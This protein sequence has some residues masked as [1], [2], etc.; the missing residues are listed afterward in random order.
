MK[1]IKLCDQKPIDGKK[2]LVSDGTAISL[3]YW[4]EFED[5]EY[6]SMGDDCY[7]SMVPTLWCKIP[8]LPKDEQ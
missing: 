3:G 8:K 4:L 7:H 2:Y 5:D 6:F 1:W